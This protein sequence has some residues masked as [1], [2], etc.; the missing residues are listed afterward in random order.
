MPR[1]FLVD[2]RDA[3][4]DTIERVIEDKELYPLIYQM[5]VDPAVYLK[6]DIDLEKAAATAKI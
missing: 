1:P 3:P 2:L 4:P 5:R 6:E